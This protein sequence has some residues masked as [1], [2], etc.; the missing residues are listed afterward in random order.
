MIDLRQPRPQA[1]LGR[2]GKKFNAASNHLQDHDINIGQVSIEVDFD[3]ATRSMASSYGI[4][5]LVGRRHHF[6]E[7]SKTPAVFKVPYHKMPMT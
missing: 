7:A 5:E 3:A 6:H 1:R 2:E 4:E